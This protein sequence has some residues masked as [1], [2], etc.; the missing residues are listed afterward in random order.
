[1][2]LLWYEWDI[3]IIMYLLPAGSMFS[4]DNVSQIFIL[5]LQF[6]LSINFTQQVI[7]L[8]EVIHT[9]AASILTIHDELIIFMIYL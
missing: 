7:F 9:E 3:S 1:M 5:S 4:L 8:V 6:K 2:G